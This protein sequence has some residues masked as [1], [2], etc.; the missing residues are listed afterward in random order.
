MEPLKALFLKKADYRSEP[1]KKSIKEYTLERFKPE[2]LKT[3]LQFVWRFE[4]GGF[5]KKESLK[6]QR[7]DSKKLVYALSSFCFE[8]RMELGD[9]TSMLK[10]VWQI[11][12][13]KLD[14]DLLLQFLGYDYVLRKN[15]EFLGLLQV[16][17]TVGERVR[18]SEREADQEERRSKKSLL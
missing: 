11:E 5:Y 13:L 10:T 8:H 3:M 12:D 9:L 16:R 1:P 7:L 2:D 15:K 14:M 6:K 18:R 4:R 17:E